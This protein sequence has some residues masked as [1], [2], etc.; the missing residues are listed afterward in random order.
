M[1]IG[2]SWIW[3]L[4]LLLVVAL[5]WWWM[6]GGARQAGGPVTPV[7]VRFPDVTVAMGAMRRSRCSGQAEGSVTVTVAYPAPPPDPRATIEVRLRVVNARDVSASLDET[8]LTFNADGNRSVRVTADLTNACAAGEFQ[9]RA[10][11][12]QTGSSQPLETSAISNVASVD[13]EP[14]TVLSFPA[15]AGYDTYPNFKAEFEIECCPAA[16]LPPRWT[17]ESANEVHV[18]GVTFTPPNFQCPGAVRH[19]ITVRGR[20]TN[21]QETGA[22]T[23][24]VNGPVRCTLG[25]IRVE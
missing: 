20:K 19:A 5:V 21:Q 10:E 18:A 6:R 2:P 24:R 16:G 11:V 23:V 9:V 7:P 17:F 22:F 4:L 25:T 3:L 15:E 12:R 1:F 13:A 14:F 8:T